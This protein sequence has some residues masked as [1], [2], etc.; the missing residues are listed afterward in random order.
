[1]EFFEAALNLVTSDIGIVVIV[2]IVAIMFAVITMG[3]RKK[4]KESFSD[5]RNTKFDVDATYSKDGSVIENSGNGN[6]DSEINIKL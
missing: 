4:I 2:L 6:Q 1:M 3:K 5:N